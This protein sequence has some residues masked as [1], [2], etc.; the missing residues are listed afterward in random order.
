MTISPWLP[1]ILAVPVLLLGEWLVR[2]IAFLDRF[3]I[4]APVIGGLLVSLA[5]LAFNL[6]SDGGIKL[7]T[8]VTD[9]WWTWLVTI[10]PEWARSPARSVSFPMMAAFFTC[11]GLNATWLVV[12]KASVQVVLFLALATVL[13]AIQNGVG[14]GVARAIGADPLLGIVC[15]SASMTGGHGTALGFA[16]V[17]AKL[18]LQNAAVLGAAAA[19]VGL[20]AGGLLGGPVGGYLIRRRGL[21][22]EA[23]VAGRPASGG[24]FGEAGIL[25]DL[26]AAVRMGR[27]V[28]G[29]LLLVLACIKAGAWVSHFLVSATGRQFSA[30]IGAMIVGVVVRNGLDLAGRRWIRSDTIDV[31]AS[32]SLGLFLAV[33]MMSLNLV[34]LAHTAV[35]MLVILSVQVVVM[36]LFAVYVTYVLMGR[37]YDAAVMAGGHCGFGLGAT[38]NA[39]ANMKSLVERYGPSPRAFLVVPLVGAVLIDFTNALVITLF[40]DVAK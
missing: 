34:E 40:L 25:G 11:V 33:A 19:T 37:D 18:G 24:A 27:P 32:I 29:H 5:V 17:F 4:P 8:N 2:R 28:I 22:P 23:A 3:N 20:V 30:Q 15:G 36:G 9:R 10:E 6:A 1:L 21:Q 31:L 12:R 7:A 26:R 14:I 38:P 13:A 39:V 16:D 35:P